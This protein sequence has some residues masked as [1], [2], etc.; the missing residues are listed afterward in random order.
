VRALDV[1][2][3][4]ASVLPTKTP[5]FTR[6]VPVSALT[7]SG[8]VM[9]AVCGEKHNLDPGDVVVILGAVVPISITSLVRVGTVGTLV[10]ASKH[11]LTP[12]VATTVTI[13]GA[14]EADF[15]GTFE[16][17]NIIDN[18]TI[19][20]TMPD[21]GAVTAT[22]SP[23]LEGAESA[24][25]QFNGA[26]AVLETP[27]EST[28]T[29]AHALAATLP[30]PIGT[31]TARVKPRISATATPDRIIQVYTEQETND[32]WAFVV[33]GDVV[34]SKSRAIK[35]DGVDRLQSNNYYRQQIIQ[36]FTLYVLMPTAGS[37]A[38][39]PARDLAEDLFQPICQS[40]L[41]KAFDSRLYSGA[42]SNLVFD[43]HGTSSY[44]TSVYVHA[45]NFE[46]TVDLN[47]EDTVGPDLDVA[48]ECIDLTLTPEV[49]GGTGLAVL[50][51]S[52]LTLDEAAVAVTPAPSFPPQTQSLH[53]NLSS[54][55]IEVVRDKTDKTVGIADAWT[56]AMWVQPKARA[57]TASGTLFM[58]QGGTVANGIRITTNGS[59]TNDPIQ[60][61]TWSPTTAVIKDYEYE[62]V[63]TEDEWLFMVF[64]WDGPT[65]T[66]LAYFDGALVA[67]TTM[68]S[69]NAGT[70]T[71]IVREIAIGANRSTTP[72]DGAHYYYHSAGMWSSVLTGDEVAELF[73]GAAG[74]DWNEDSGDYASSAS[75]VHWWRFGF[76]DTDL[77]SVCFDYVDGGSSF[78]LSADAVSVSVPADLVTASPG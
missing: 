29:F 27:T 75:L 8:T 17:T 59:Q 77:T 69:D 39:R 35:S 11:D 41:F 22:G 18:L 28:F 34:S 68:N 63:Q 64:T 7:G 38:G 20:F 32:L 76:D 61:E 13:S 6:T 9:T 21:S 52:A 55:T 74:I 60:I 14:T 12:A 16:I 1:V 72:G 5:Y 30:T 67:A 66:L 62:S 58:M 70:M 48:F 73:A 51:A 45:Y 23:V 47:F 3:R 53:L 43:S 36:P 26:Y 25:R 71:D 49:D 57:L 37:V 46:Q 2:S 24:L 44:D 50:T 65:D 4:L 40:L 78:D 33:L 19:Q 15:N 31:I 10:L 54:G 56:V 42:E